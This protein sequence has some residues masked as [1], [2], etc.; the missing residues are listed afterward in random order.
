MN[1]KIWSIDQMPR[2]ECHKGVNDVMMALQQ[3][4]NFLIYISCRKKAVFLSAGKS[5]TFLSCEDVT[6][7]V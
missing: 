5:F 1:M 4:I 3:N 2:G 7:N 6:T